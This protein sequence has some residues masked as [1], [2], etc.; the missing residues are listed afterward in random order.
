MIY[1]GP[2]KEVVDDDNNRMERGRRYAVC[3]KTYHLLKK[4]PYRD[5]FEFIDPRPEI[6]IG[7]ARP[8]NLSRD[9]LRHPK[10]TKGENYAA[11][12]GPSQCCDSGGCC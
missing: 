1:K 5:Y 10:E 2:F 9:A 3:D 12:T 8:F 11:T 6:P 4:A 7:K